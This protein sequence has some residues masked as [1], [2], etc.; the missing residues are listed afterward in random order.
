[1]TNKVSI[2]KELEKSFSRNTKYITLPFYF[3]GRPLE[4]SESEKHAR[5]GMTLLSAGTMR[6]RW[7]ETNENRDKTIKEILAEIKKSFPLE[8]RYRGL[9]IKII[10][11]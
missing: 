5:W 2:K 1:M 4:S 10:E 11:L 6:F 7:N 8:K 3:E 9:T